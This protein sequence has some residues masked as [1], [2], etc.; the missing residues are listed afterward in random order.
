MKWGGIINLVVIGW[1]GVDQGIWG[2]TFMY[3]YVYGGVDVGGS[4]GSGGGDGGDGGEL[5]GGEGGKKRK[6]FSLLLYIQTTRVQRVKRQTTANLRLHICIHTLF[7]PG[8]WETALIP[9]W[10]SVWIC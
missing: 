1:A 9:L 8:P 7:C 6:A 10:S 2:G 3:P 5:G 4:G